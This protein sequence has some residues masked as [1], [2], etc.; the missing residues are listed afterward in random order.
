MDPYALTPGS[1]STKLEKITS[2]VWLEIS[3]WPP[4]LLRI[5]DGLAI[6]SLRMRNS[7]RTLCG[8]RETTYGWKGI[9]GAR[10]GEWWGL[11]CG[12]QWRFSLVLGASLGWGF[13]PLLLNV[14]YSSCKSLVLRNTSHEF[15][16]Q[17]V[18]D[19]PEFLFGSYPGIV[20]YEHIWTATT[21]NV[22]RVPNISWRLLTPFLTL[23]RI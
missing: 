10:D 5:L 15:P 14:P 9:Q 18:H 23:V 21:S 19:L 22:R 11:H 3:L 1:R 16:R 8:R 4:P 6:P 20:V 7:T 12:I 13:F 2:V 17:V